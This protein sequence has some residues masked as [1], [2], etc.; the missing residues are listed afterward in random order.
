MADAAL[1]IGFGP[2]ISGRERQALATFNEALAY[3]TRLQTDGD[4]ESFEPVLLEPHG[5]DLGG[6][7][8]LRGDADKLNRVRVSEEFIRLNVR[9]ALVVQNFGV[10]SAYI[11]AAFGQQLTMFEAQ[12]ADIG[13]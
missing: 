3:N 6:F 4:I 13:R 2:V 1:F 7:V 11:G 8:L 10:V 12:L 5:G 9:S